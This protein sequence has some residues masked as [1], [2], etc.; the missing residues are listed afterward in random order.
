MAMAMSLGSCK[1]FL[2]VKPKT[3][4]AENMFFTSEQGFQQALNGVYSLM[5]GRNLYGDKLTMGYVSALG[6]EYNITQDNT[7]VT[8]MNLLTAVQLNHT[9]D[10]SKTN[11]A[12]I[13]NTAYAA[14]ANLNKIIENTTLNKAVLN[15]NNA[16]ALIRGEALGLRALLHFDLYRLFG[17]EYLANTKAKAIPYRIVVNETSDVPATSEEVIKYALADLKEAA[18]LLK[19]TDPIVT[20]VTTTTLTNVL[21]RREHLNYYGV[22]ALEARVRITMGD[23]AG[24]AAAASEVVASGTYPFVTGAAAAAPTNRD[25]LY[26]SEQIFMLRNNEMTS[27]TN[28]Y[29]QN[30]STGPASRF[31]RPEADYLSLYETASGGSTDYRYL[32]R[33]EPNGGM[34]LPSKFW[35]TTL[36]TSIAKTNLD[37]YVPVIRLAEMYYIL[38]EAAATPAEGIGYLNTVRAARALV[39]LISNGTQAQLDAELLKEYQKELYSEGQLFFYYKRK[40]ATTMRF[41]TAA[42]S[43][44]MYVIP[45]PDTELQFN[46][47]Y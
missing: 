40:N 4:L 31:T 16:Y 39:A 47:T 42:V 44:D 19:T 1:K 5:A 27:Y 33:I 7:A 21:F 46:P 13:W 37:Q 11:A 29:F 28:S 43:P 26:L 15:E 36:N 18:E 17:K 6:Q 30:A 22:K 12:A 34:I 10:A 2:D 9:A 35:Q 38:A 3:S 24:A 45:V 41:R 8:G 14:I 20:K 23:K 25:R 32:Y